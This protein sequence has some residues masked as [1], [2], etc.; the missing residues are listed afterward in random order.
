MEY[1]KAIKVGNSVAVTIPPDMGIEIGD[2]VSVDKVGK[3]GSVL[4]TKVEE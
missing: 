3:S 4:L 1:R 2:H